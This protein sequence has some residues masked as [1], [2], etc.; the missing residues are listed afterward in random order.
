[1]SFL[2]ELRHSLEVFVHIPA[3]TFKQYEGNTSYPSSVSAPRIK[4][5]D[6]L[7]LCNSY[8]SLHRPSTS[9]QVSQ[10]G[11]TYAVLCSVRT[12]TLVFTRVTTNKMNQANVFETNFYN[13]L[14]RCT[15]HFEDSLNITHQ[16]MH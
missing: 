8:F 10:D 13:Y 16:Q 2:S 5:F 1:M 4:Q 14:Y 3:S 9:T 11:L 15:V 6:P 12:P 7:W